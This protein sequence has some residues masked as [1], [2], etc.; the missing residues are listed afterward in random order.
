MQTLRDLQKAFSDFLF[1][2]SETILNGVVT[3]SRVDKRTRLEIYKNAYHIRLRKCIETDHPVL[4]S[5]L[6][7]ELFEKMVSGYTSAH[8]SSNASLRQFGDQL[9]WYL[10]SEEPF[11]LIPVL[12]EI[13]AFERRML[14]S[15]DAADA[16]RATLSDLQAVAACSWPTLRIEFHPSVRV[17]ESLWNCVEIWQAIKNGEQPPDAVKANESNWL[18]W[19][20]R[21]RLTRFG[22]LKADGLA[23]IRG[24][25]T[26]KSFAEICER[27][28]DIV[29]EDEVSARAAGYLN[30]WVNE[31]IISRFLTED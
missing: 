17:F 6:G 13:A 7:D 26:G 8:P 3:D 27:L 25:E 16:C 23:M 19:R 24:F 10:K 4:G 30:T 9:P 28:A 20:N 12:A 15:F 31:G 21:A 22:F 18:V 29:P 5:Y 2:E 1:S 14:F 11:S